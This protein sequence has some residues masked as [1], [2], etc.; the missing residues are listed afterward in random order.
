MWLVRFQFCK[1]SQDF[2]RKEE[3]VGTDW[4][5]ELFEKCS[6]SPY[7]WSH[8]VTLCFIAAVPRERLDV[9]KV[10]LLILERIKVIA[11][12]EVAQAWFLLF[13]FFLIVVKCS[14]LSGWGW[15]LGSGSKLTELTTFFWWGVKKIFRHIPGDFTGGPVAKTLCSQC[16]GP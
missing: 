16:T 6:W 9:F 8:T 3:G 12:W 15:E 4:A 13:F 11:G 14:F 2:F 10:A 7:C 1:V 5:P